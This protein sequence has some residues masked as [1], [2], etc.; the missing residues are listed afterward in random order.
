[1]PS[2]SSVPHGGTDAYKPSIFSGFVA[3]PPRVG[4]ITFSFLLL[5]FSSLYLST[6]LNFS[7]ILGGDLPAPQCWPGI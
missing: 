4:N 3:S 2:Y 6:V 5:S 7:V 1:M